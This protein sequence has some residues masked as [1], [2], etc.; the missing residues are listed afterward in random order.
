MLEIIGTLTYDKIILVAIGCVI[1]FLKTRIM[2][3]KVNSKKMKEFIDFFNNKK[4][5]KN[6]VS[7]ENIIIY[8]FNFYIKYNLL[9]KL[10]KLE[11]PT[12]AILL[13]IKTANILDFEDENLHFKNNSLLTTKRKRNWIY[14]I[15]FILGIVF[16]IFSFI[17]FIYFFGLFSNDGNLLNENSIISFLY[18][19]SL[20][21]GYILITKEAIRIKD[22]EELIKIFNE[23]YLSDD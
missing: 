16:F 23:K 17:S 8:R 11:N 9:K 19:I 6:R 21:Y 1:L 3:D 13:Y 4:N 10:L 2:K 22:A 18:G 15:N 7:L 14:Y 5:L 20:F 12:N